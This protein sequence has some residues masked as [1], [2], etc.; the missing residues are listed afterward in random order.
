MLMNSLFA[1]ITLNN[2]LGQ[3]VNLHVC[4]I[5]QQGRNCVFVAAPSQ[6]ASSLVAKNAEPFAFQLRELFALDAGKF[7]L[8]E[9]REAGELQHLY[10]W[11]FEWVGNSPLSARV[12]EVSSAGQRNMLFSL[13]AEPADKLLA[14]A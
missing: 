10:R 7:E 6:Q 14:S 5:R 3:Q 1:N 4:H 8:I 13:I 2:R 12:E 11:R 9:I